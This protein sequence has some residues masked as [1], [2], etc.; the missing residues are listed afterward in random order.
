MVVYKFGEMGSAGEIN[1]LAENLANEGDV[2]SLKAMAAENGI[3]PYA[4][5]LYMQGDLAVL[6]GE[7]DAALGKIDVEEQDLKP[8]ELLKDWVEYLKGQVYEN[9]ELARA[10]RM[11]GKS[12][13]GMIAYLMAWAF[14][15]QHP[16]SDDIKKAAGVSAGKVT[17]GIPGMGTAKKLIRAYYLE[18]TK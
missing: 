5:D 2:D 7:E 18:E 3:D 10:V 15:H 12:L 8:D 1:E 16:V 11:K 4:V 13:A 14:K 9:M 17:F 6:C